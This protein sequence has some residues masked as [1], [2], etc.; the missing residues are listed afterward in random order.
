MCLCHRCLEVLIVKP[1]ETG[2]HKKKRPM[3]G[4]FPGAVQNVTQPIFPHILHTTHTTHIFPQKCACRD[5]IMSVA[6]NTCCCDKTF[7]A[8]QI[9][10]VAAPANDSP[11]HSP[12]YPS[13]PPTSQHL[14]HRF[15]IQYNFLAKCQYT[16]CTSNIL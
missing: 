8:T 3:Q 4:S 2:N 7:F 9:I 1:T 14:Q 15:S 16:D 12:S 5:K 6:T 13:V 10:L 11:P